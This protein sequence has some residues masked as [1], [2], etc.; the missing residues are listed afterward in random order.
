MTMFCPSEDLKNES[1]VEQKLLTPLLFTAAPRGLGYSSVD[2][3]TKPNIRF[4]LIGKGETQKRYHPDYIVLI[5]GIPILIIEAKTPGEDPVEA[6]REARLYA[7][8]L[9]SLFATS[10]VSHD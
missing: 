3:R 4:L 1:D 5:A 6:M 7:T 10:T 2:V 9:N 8:E